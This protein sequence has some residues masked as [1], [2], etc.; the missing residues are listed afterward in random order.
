VITLDLA[1]DM[2]TSKDAPAYTIAPSAELVLEIGNHRFA[3]RDAGSAAPDAVHVV[4]GSAGYHR[5]T[6]SGTRVILSTA[7][8]DPVKGGAFKGFE[9]GESYLVAVGAEAPSAADG[10]MRFAPLWTAKVNVAA[11]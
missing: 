11:K 2:I 10:A 7:S 4:H 6:F 5:A 3:T 1:H 8:L 9:A